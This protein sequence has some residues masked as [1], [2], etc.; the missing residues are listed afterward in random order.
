M[1]TSLARNQRKVCYSHPSDFDFPIYSVNFINFLQYQIRD[2]T[3]LSSALK[4]IYLI[5]LSVLAS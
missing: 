2:Y 3:F 4:S 5:Y 1:I